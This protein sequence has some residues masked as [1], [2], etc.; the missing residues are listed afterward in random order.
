MGAALT[1]VLSRAD[2]DDIRIFR[3]DGNAAERERSLFAENGREGDTSIGGLPQPAERTGDVPHAGVLRI[4]VDV[5]DTAGGE[6]GSEAAQLE[7]LEGGCIECAA[8]L[9]GQRNC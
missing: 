9:S 4:D 6:C 1:G 8:I 3:I 2:P 5:L 7:S